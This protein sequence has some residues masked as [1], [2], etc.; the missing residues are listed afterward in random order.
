MTIAPAEDDNYSLFALSGGEKSSKHSCVHKICV[1]VYLAALHP[2]VLES[3]QSDADPVEEEQTKPKSKA[4]SRRFKL[5]DEVK[6]YVLKKHVYP[7]HD[8]RSVFLFLLYLLSLPVHSFGILFSRLIYPH[9]PRRLSAVL[10]TR[11]FTC[12]CTHPDRRGDGSC[13]C[14][15]PSMMHGPNDFNS[16]PLCEEK[17]FEEKLQAYM[18]PTMATL[19]TICGAYANCTVQVK[20]CS[21]CN[22]DFPPYPI[23]GW[24]FL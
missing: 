22:M 20:R 3:L 14:S 19:H 5:T 12:D 4:S 23:E 9:S 24:F 2:G 13:K 7:A 11:R 17:G 15:W 18:L 10:R 8:E 21:R 1:F 16:C 6:T